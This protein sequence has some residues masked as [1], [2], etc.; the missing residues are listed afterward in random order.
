MGNELI[1]LLV[2]FALTTVCGGVLTFFFQRRQA[3]YQW[4]KS[5]WEKELSESQAA[6]EEISRLLDRRLYRTRQFLW[7]FDRSP[8]ELEAR[9]GEYRKAVTRWNDNV[10]RILALLA[11]HFSDEIRN[12]LDNDLGAEFV[13]VGRLL[14]QAY[15][16]NK[17]DFERLPVGA[18]LAWISTAR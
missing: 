5:R 6:F 4:I 16:H 10:N 1:K 18:R 9:L 12:I 15:F 14:E 3:Q 7:G 17:G 13:N 2:G 8:E 11:I